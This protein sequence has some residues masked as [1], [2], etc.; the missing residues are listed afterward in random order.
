VHEIVSEIAQANLTTRA[1]DSVVELVGSEGLPG[2]CTW[3]DDVRSQ[4]KYSWSA[5]LHYVNPNDNVKQVFVCL[6]P[7]QPLTSWFSAAPG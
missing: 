1:Y 2:I 3:A 7:L 6:F 4:S 5:V